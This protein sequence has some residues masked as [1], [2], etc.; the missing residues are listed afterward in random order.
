MNVKTADLKNNLSRYLRR[1]RETGETIL[2][3]D[4]DQPVATLA[5]L[6][7]DGD[8]EWARFRTEAVARA[9]AV[10]LELDLP[11][12]RPPLRALPR[13]MPGVAPDGRIDVQTADLLREGKPY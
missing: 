6:Q 5:P 2:V 9:E 10:G 1:I 4:R 13:L 8:S 11:E 7:R 12:R 3:C